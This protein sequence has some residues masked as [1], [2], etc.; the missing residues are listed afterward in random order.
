MSAV[1]R[2][3]PEF[4]NIAYHQL[5][6][7][8]VADIRRHGW[9]VHGVR[10]IAYKDHGDTPAHHLF[11]AKRAIQHTHIG[12][13]AHNQYLLDLPLTEAKAKLVESF[14]QQAIARALQNHAGNV[15]AAA[16][17]LGIHRQSLQQKITQLGIRVERS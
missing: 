17:Q 16:R 10:Q 1:H 15:S 5:D 14:E 7:V 4:L 12:V 8:I 6:T 11:N 2:G 13:N 9:I 3:A